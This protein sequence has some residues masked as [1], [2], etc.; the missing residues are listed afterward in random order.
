MY[1]CELRCTFVNRP[2]CPTCLEDLDSGNFVFWQNWAFCPLCLLPNMD[3]PRI[4]GL[5]VL[6]DLLDP[7][8]TARYRRLNFFTPQNRPHHPVQLLP[9]QDRDRLFLRSD[10]P[11]TDGLV[12]DDNPVPGGSP[13]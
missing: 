8:H 2:L 5:R 6:T 1:T 7:R 12:V 10:I 3:G 4:D 13:V 9:A 11:L